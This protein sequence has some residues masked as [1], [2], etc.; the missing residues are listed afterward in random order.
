MRK[1]VLLLLFCLVTATAAAQPAHVYWGVNAA[2]TLRQGEGG[3]SL[4]E[5]VR[6]VRAETGGRI[7]SAETVNEN[8]RRVHRIKVLTPDQRVRIVTVDAERGRRN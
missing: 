5:A 3:M 8:G 1:L 4:D 7:L 2:K 6:R